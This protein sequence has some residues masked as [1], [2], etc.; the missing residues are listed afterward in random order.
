MFLLRKVTLVLD[1]ICQIEKL[2][3]AISN[4][5]IN[6]AMLFFQNLKLL[7][8]K[9]EDVE[10][11]LAEIPNTLNEMS[12][13]PPP[14]HP[15]PS[16]PPPPSPQFNISSEESIYARIDVIPNPNFVPTES[17]GAIPKRRPMRKST[18]IYKMMNELDN[19][20]AAKLDVTEMEK[21]VD[22]PKAVVTTKQ[23]DEQQDK[24]VAA[25]SKLGVTEK[26]TEKIEVIGMDMIVVN[27]ETGAQSEQW[28]EI[29]LTNGTENTDDMPDNTFFYF[30]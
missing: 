18:R 20:E 13:P 11:V 8:H 7:E 6:N 5:T 14:M 2:I 4:L 28:K 19:N 24:K 27:P 22:K 16:P 26:E 12:P 1:L 23:Q 25:A 29:K 9:Y 3:E 10:N 21:I 17:T 15:P 30:E